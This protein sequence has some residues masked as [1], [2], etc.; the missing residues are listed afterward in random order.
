MPCVPTCPL[1]SACVGEAFGSFGLMSAWHA[2]ACELRKAA[3]LFVCLDVFVALLRIGLGLGFVLLCRFLD[4]EP[5]PAQPLW[6]PSA[7]PRGVLYELEQ[8]RIDLVMR[9]SRD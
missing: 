1:L 5:L 9:G 8:C 4:P 3:L 6:S 7:L 2:S